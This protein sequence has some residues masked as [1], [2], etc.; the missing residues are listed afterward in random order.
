[1]NVKDYVRQALIKEVER[2]G[3]DRAKLVGVKSLCRQIKEDLIEENP[4]ADV[5]SIKQL[6]YAVHRVKKEL[7]L[8]TQKRYSRVLDLEN[9]PYNITDV[10]Y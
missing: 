5:P 1:M 3:I 7:G 2:I 4:D 10:D 9:G 8:G 6:E